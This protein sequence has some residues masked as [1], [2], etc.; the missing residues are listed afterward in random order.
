MQ[1]Q[2][3]GGIVLLSRTKGENPN[4]TISIDNEGIEKRTCCKCKSIKPLSDFYNN[5]NGTIRGTCKS[6]YAE[7][8][9]EYR[10]KCEWLITAEEY[11]ELMKQPCDYCGFF[12]EQTGIGLDKLIQILNLIKKIILFLVVCGAILLNPMLFLMNI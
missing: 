6:C 4:Y 8:H 11:L 5:P 7:R 9:K 12:L 2:R 3:H 1:R 10:K